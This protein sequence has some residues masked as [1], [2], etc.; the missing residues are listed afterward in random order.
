MDDKSGKMLEVDKVIEINLDTGTSITIKNENEKYRIPEISNITKQVVLEILRDSI[1]PEDGHRYLAFWDEETMIERILQSSNK[2]ITEEFR[3]KKLD[4]SWGW[5]RQKMSFKDTKGG[6]I[7][8]CR[9]TDI[10]E[11]KKQDE[12]FIQEIEKSRR[13][14][15]LTGLLRAKVFFH[16]VE[17]AARCRSKVRGRDAQA[18]L[19]G[20]EVGAEAHDPAAGGAARLVCVPGGAACA[21]GRLFP[22][23]A[24]DQR[25]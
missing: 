4:G 21:A 7:V 3:Q 24:P 14:D 10:D 18:R 5:V 1:H 12:A 19:H 23:A 22:G 17:A 20:V 11:E 25:P 6:A 2:M 16:E 13:I 9:I 15:R 8:V